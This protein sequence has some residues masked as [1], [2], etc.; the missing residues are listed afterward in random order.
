MWLKVDSGARQV[1]PLKALKCSSMKG[2]LLFFSLFQ[3]FVENVCMMEPE[4]L[5]RDFCFSK[6]FIL[7][8]F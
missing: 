5:E 8:I 6:V 7:Q 3:A 1:W 4:G 2:G